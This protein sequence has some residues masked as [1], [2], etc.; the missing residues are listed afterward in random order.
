MP[1]LIQADDAAERMY[2]C[3]SCG[4]FETAFARRFVCGLRILRCLPYGLF[5]PLVRRLVADA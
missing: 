4:H 1:F 5:F 3:L 2:L